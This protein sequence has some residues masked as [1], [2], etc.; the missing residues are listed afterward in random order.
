MGHRTPRVCARRRAQHRDRRGAFRFVTGFL[1]TRLFAVL[2]AYIIRYNTTTL[3]TLFGCEPRGGE[4][5]DVHA[6]RAPQSTTS[7]ASRRARPLRGASH[8][9]AEGMAARYASA[10]SYFFSCSHAHRSATPS[11]S[12][13]L[14]TTLCLQRILLQVLAAVGIYSSFLNMLCRVARAA[15]RLRSVSMIWRK[16]ANRFLCEF[17]CSSAW[18]CKPYGS[19]SLASSSS[20]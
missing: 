19:L 4:K 2:V 7:K 5:G 20:R 12:N 18:N 6:P 10:S 8:S 9:Q 11:Y 14:P 13:A 1:V 17:A 3:Q 16:T 15:S